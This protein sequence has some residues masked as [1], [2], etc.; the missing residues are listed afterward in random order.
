MKTRNFSG[1]ALLVAAALVGSMTFA[2]AQSRT[3]AGSGRSSSTSSSSY[4]SSGHSG[5]SYGRSAGY[6]SSRSAGYSSSRPASYSSSR[7]T[8]YSSSRAASYS[9]SSS[10]TSSSYSSARP[11]S[12]ISSSRPK[13]EGHVSRELISSRRPA[14]RPD[15]RP[16]YRPYPHHGH[17]HYFRP[18]PHHIHPRYFCTYFP[19]PYFGCIFRREVYWPAP[20]VVYVHERPYYYDRGVF[21]INHGADQYEAVIPPVGAIVPVIPEDYTIVTIDGYDY[22]QVDRTL[23]KYIE[24]NGETAF[25]VVAQLA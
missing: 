2:N 15:R 22:Y 20:L 8:G 25:E 13:T 21:F 16:D 5:S 17:D 7:P 24:Y 11:Q 4:R 9:G 14:H 23:Y 18:N 10:R 12:S 3:G 1:A 19:R 6:S